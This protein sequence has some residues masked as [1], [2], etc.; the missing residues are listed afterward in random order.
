M[1]VKTNAVTKIGSKEFSFLPS[2][3]SIYLKW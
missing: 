1:Q 3:A 2:C